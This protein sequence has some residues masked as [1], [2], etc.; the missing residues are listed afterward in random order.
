MLLLFFEFWFRD[1]SF[2]FFFIYLLCF[3]FYLSLSLSLSFYF[4]F[5]LSFYLSLILPSFTIEQTDES[6]LIF[7]TFLLLLWSSYKLHWEAWWLWLLKSDKV[8]DWWLF[9]FEFL[10]YFI[11]LCSLYVYTY[12]KGLVREFVSFEPVFFFLLLLSFFIIFEIGC[13]LSFLIL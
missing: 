7:F 12:F 2:L 5:Y 8:E 6:L 11:Y 10:Y 13:Y 4:Y 1:D 3:Y 9:L